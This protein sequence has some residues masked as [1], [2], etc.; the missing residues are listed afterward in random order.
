MADLVYQDLGKVALTTAKVELDALLHENTDKTKSELYDVV[1]RTI[2][3]NLKSNKT[4]DLSQEI[5]AA[6]RGKNFNIHDNHIKD[7]IKIPFSDP[8]IYS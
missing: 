4:A 1:G 2:I 7:E 8:N 3:N 6:L 5:I